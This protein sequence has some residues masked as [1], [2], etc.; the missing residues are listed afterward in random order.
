MKKIFL[1][2][3]VFI[4]VVVIIMSPYLL[5]IDFKKYSPIVLIIWFVSVA[6]YLLLKR[7]VDRHMDEKREEEE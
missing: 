2:I 6:Y 4:A 5:V 1:R 7:R 3:L